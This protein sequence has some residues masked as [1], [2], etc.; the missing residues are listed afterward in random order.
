MRPSF[1][2]GCRAG[3]REVFVA[4]RGGGIARPSHHSKIRPRRCA[5]PIADVAVIWVRLDGVIRGFLVERGM[6]GLDARPAYRWADIATPMVAVPAVQNFQRRTGRD[7]AQT[8][9]QSAMKKLRF[10]SRRRPGSEAHMPVRPDENRAILLDSEDFSEA[11][12]LRRCFRRAPASA[13]R[14]SSI[15]SV[16]VQQMAEQQAGRPDADVAEEDAERPSLLK[17]SDRVWIAPL[18]PS[19]GST[20]P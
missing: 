9:E 12:T 14:R 18:R 20:C 6:D 8:G 1:T 3:W 10:V 19:T 13:A 15:D 16:G 4:A 5:S 2:H 17:L 7:F 11:P